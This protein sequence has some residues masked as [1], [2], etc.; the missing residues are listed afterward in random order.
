VHMSLVF[1]CTKQPVHVYTMLI[2]EAAQACKL[3]QASAVQSLW[4]AVGGFGVV[5]LLSVG[6]MQF[7]MQSIVNNG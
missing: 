6:R 2:R 3:C 1:M 5:A 4:Y 7:C